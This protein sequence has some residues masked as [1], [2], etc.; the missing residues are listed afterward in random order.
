MGLVPK[1]YPCTDGVE[2]WADA[3]VVVLRPHALDRP[4]FVVGHARGFCLFMCAG[5]KNLQ[6][7]PLQ[8]HLACE[9]FAIASQDDFGCVPPPS[10]WVFVFLPTSFVLVRDLFP[11]LV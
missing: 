2:D 11:Y 1:L 8:I 10:N 6:R 5:I 9:D 3:A 4:G 7:F